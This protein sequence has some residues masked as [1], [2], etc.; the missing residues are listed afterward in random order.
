MTALHDLPAHALLAAYRTGDL[1][2]VEVARAV[3]DHIARWEPHLCAT[4]LLRP[5]EALAW[6]WA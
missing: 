3:L 6:A 5:E 2:P 4:Y 1:S